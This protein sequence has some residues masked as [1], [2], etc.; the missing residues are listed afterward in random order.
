MA[1]RGL[2]G[3]PCPLPQGSG[4]RFPCCMGSWPRRAE[5]TG[6]C[7]FVRLVYPAGKAA[8]TA[9][10]SAPSGTRKRVS[11]QTLHLS[12]RRNVHARERATSDQRLVRQ[13]RARSNLAEMRT[14]PSTDGQC[15]LAARRSLINQLSAQ[16]LCWGLTP[17]FVGKT[18][19]S[20]T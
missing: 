6:V 1:C 13:S 2:S 3:K 8:I 9:E 14:R 10:F 15:L 18:D 20:K 7:S 11:D 4:N 12:E 5:Q 19:E 16:M 17:M